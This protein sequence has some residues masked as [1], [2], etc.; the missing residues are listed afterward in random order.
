M[1]KTTLSIFCFCIITS[2]LITPG[3]ITSKPEL[4]PMQKRQVTTKL[5][6]GSYDNIFASTITVFQDN[7][8]IIKNTDKSTGLIT[9]EVS[10]DAGALTRVLAIAASSKVYDSG[11]KVEIN[12]MV[13]KISSSN[14]EIRIRIQESNFNNAGGITNTQQIYDEKT[15]TDFFNNI[16]TEVKRREAINR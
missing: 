1:K 15:Y 11:T 5:I 4:S 10:R 7:E 12:A 14:S 8:F 2:L 6:D 13:N 3:C 16:Q 9:A